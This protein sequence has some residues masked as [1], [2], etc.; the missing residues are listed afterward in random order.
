MYLM[1]AWHFVG[2][3]ELHGGSKPSSGSLGRLHAGGGFE[4]KTE[5]KVAVRQENR[6]A[7]QAGGMLQA[8]A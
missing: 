4:L 8:N 3:Q 6:R 1:Y 2:F 5:Q 7:M